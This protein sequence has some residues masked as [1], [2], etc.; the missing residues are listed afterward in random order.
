MVYNALK[1]EY[2]INMSERYIGIHCQ[3]SV[4][5]I[6]WKLDYD[7]NGT[8]G[9]VTYIETRRW[10][11]KLPWICV[12]TWPFLVA[13]ICLLKVMAKIAFGWLINCDKYCNDINGY[14]KT[15]LI[16]M[17]FGCSQKCHENVIQCHY[18]KCCNVLRLQGT[19]A[20]YMYII[21]KYHSTCVVYCMCTI[22]LSN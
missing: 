20:W 18:M 15:I 13:R 2:S 8:N 17:A 7:R 4:L 10:P 11:Y 6:S 12:I 21:W 1:C 14:I 19:I 5:Y 3:P 16:W 9:R 22:P